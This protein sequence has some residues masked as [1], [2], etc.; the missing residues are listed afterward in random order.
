L[1]DRRFGLVVVACLLLFAALINE[2]PDTFLEY[3]RVLAWPLVAGAT[4]LLFRKPL[5]SMFEGVVL[6]ALG[7]GASAPNSANAISS[8]RPNANSTVSRLWWLSM[9]MS[10]KPSTAAMMT[11][12]TR[13]GVSKRNPPPALQ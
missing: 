5:T 2:S 4:V 11:R 1:W 12:M 6:K 9:A 10:S 13:S 3:L 7:Q 8:S